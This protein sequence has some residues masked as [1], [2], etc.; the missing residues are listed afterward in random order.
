MMPAPLR[1]RI[2]SARLAWCVLLGIVLVVVVL[3]RIRLLEFPL[4]RDEGEYAYAGQLLLQGIPPYQL[5]YNMKFPGTYAAYA[6][7]MAV[8]GETTRGVHL[9]LLLVNG[10]AIAL[11]LFLGRRLINWSAGLAA[12]AGYAVLSLSS[13]VLGFAGHATHFV[14]VPALAGALLLLRTAPSLKLVYASGF[15]FG[16]GVLMKQPGL[17]FVLFGGGFLLYRDSVAGVPWNVR[18]SRNATFLTGAITPLVATALLLWQAGVFEK[19]WFWTVAY[20]REYGTLVTVAEGAPR[21]VE[22]M[23]G[24][25]ASGWTIWVLAALGLIACFWD[26]SLSRQARFFLLGLLG[27]S[28]LAVCPGFYFRQHYFVLALPAI[29]LLAGSAA[30]GAE[31]MWAGSPRLARFLPVLLFAAACAWPLVAD[32]S[33]F[34]APDPVTASRMVYGINPFPEA[35]RVAEYLRANT[36]AGDKVAV[37]GSEPQIYFYARRHS[38]TGYIYTYGL[39]EPHAF[40]ERM[41]EEMIAEIEAARPRYLV[42]VSVPTSWNA[43]TDKGVRIFDWFSDYGPKNYRI[44]GLANIHAGRETEYHIP[45]DES[46][47]PALSP[48]YVMIYERRP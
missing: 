6:L 14:V 30:A 7:L 29:C 25:L 41:Q 1:N 35:L 27:F 42:D 44:V 47:T 3:I 37:L 26:K 9:G 31:K 20:A 8:F 2:T 46:R 13:S 5:A 39:M 22:A 16:L 32:R 11:V 24:L 28:A 4:E 40:A 17:F 19:F 33:F 15:L 43:R 34:V 23:R 48:Y 36:D 45:V 12:A 38:A 10:A 18:L 21:L